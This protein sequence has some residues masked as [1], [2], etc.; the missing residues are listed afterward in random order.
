[1]Q[2]ILTILFVLLIIIGCLLLITLNLLYKPIIKEL[3]E[4]LEEYYDKERDDKNGNI[5]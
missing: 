3:W 4:Y 1:M 5:K 2:I